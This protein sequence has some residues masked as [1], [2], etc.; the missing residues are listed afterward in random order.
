MTIAS[1]ELGTAIEPHLWRTEDLEERVVVTHLGR[2]VA[3]IVPLEDLY[4][5]DRL[6]ERSADHQVF[7]V[8]GEGEAVVSTLRAE[9][10]HDA[11]DIRDG[12]EPITHPIVLVRDGKKIAAI[13]P[14]GDLRVLRELEDRI[15][16]EA[17]Q[18][19]LAEANEKGTI[20]C[21]AIKAK[22]GM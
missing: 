15:D 14:I 3:A 17:A 16:L 8:N 9:T 12:M 7:P 4:L 10:R 21:S 19:A 5:I 11:L 22:Q 20:P 6:W 18:E 1:A 13:V 2:E